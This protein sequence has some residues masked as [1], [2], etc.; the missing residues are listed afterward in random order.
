MQ[1]QNLTRELRRNLWISVALFSVTFAFFGRVLLNDFVAFDDDQS[2]YRN[3]HVQGLDWKR[4]LWMFTDATH[5]VR[6]KPLTWLSYGLIYELNG[7]DPFGY[8]LASLLLHCSNAVLMFAVI[9]RLLAL[10]A[11][12]GQIGETQPEVNLPAALGALLWAVNPLR[13]EPVARVTDLTYGQ[14]LFF[15]LLSLW[16]Y[17]P[18]PPGASINQP[19]RASYWCSVAMFAL[20]MLSYPFA[21]GYVL[22]L[23]ALDWYPLRRL[24]W[25]TPWWRQAASRRVALQKTPFL[26]L[27]GLVFATW[28]ARLNPMGDWTRLPS[29]ANLNPLKQAIQALYVWAY[30]VWKPWLP[31]HLSPLYNTLVWFNPLAWP[32]WSSAALVAG[33]TLALWRN[34]RQWPWAVVLWVAHLVLLLAALGLTERFHHTC[35]R[36]GYVPGMVW[37]VSVAAVMWKLPRRRNLQVIATGSALGLALLWGGLSFHQIGIWKNS[38]VLFEHMLG[39][40]NDRSPYRS[41]LHG[42]LGTFYADHGRVG[43]AVE[44]YQ[45]SLRLEPSV[46]GYYRLATLLE[47]NGAAE[48]ALTNY[49]RLLELH[50]DPGIHAKAAILLSGRARTTEAINHYRQALKFA[51][52]WALALNNLAWILAT[53]PEA[54]NRSGAEAVQLAERACALTHSEVPLMLGTLAAAYAEAGR[55]TEAVET[56]ERACAVAR[57]AGESEL[58]ERNRE[59]VGFYRAGQAYHEAHNTTSGD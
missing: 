25:A 16:C 1:T 34:R 24:D 10:A 3:P 51:P 42:C 43:E 54:T 33:I 45:L 37:A 47:T 36:Y 8:H 23:A 15:L 29:A 59:L 57:A 2:V 46:P 14:S 26:L 11:S 17:L 40:L 32:F 52:D 4:V 9:R 49:L 56:G 41:V 30:Y 31:L 5:A 6:Y 21:F 7:L 19:R 12:P 50:P 44:Q 22:V 28:L 39:Q 58:A 38:E 27:G 20:S 48:A 55:F 35:D 53:A 13:V 18:S